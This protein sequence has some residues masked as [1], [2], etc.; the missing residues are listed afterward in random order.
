MTFALEQLAGV[1]V[2]IGRL[3]PGFQDTDHGLTASDVAM[4]GEG[5][6][7]EDTLHGI[8]LAEHSDAHGV[9]NRRAPAERQAAAWPDCAHL[10]RR[11]ALLER[12]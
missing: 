4:R 7:I 11:V 10:H 9:D 6:R 8:D 1:V 3:Q 2:G 12:K 5:F